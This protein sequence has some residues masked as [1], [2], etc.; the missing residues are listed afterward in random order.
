MHRLTGEAFFAQ[1]ADRWKDYARSRWK[2]S[3]AK[4]RKAWFKI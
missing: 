2:R 3:R 4:D 1:T